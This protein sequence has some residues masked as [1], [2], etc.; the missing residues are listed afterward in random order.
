MTVQLGT[1]LPAFSLATTGQKTLTHADFIGRYSVL[2]F[3]PKDATPGCTTEGQD[4]NRLL[5]EFAKQNTSIYGVSLDS[6]ESH[7]RFKSQQGFTFELIS[8]P[9]AELSSALGVYQ[10]KKNFGKEYMGIVRSTFVIDPTG[11]ICAL[12]S[13]VKVDGHAA[14]VLQTIQQL[15]P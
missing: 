15:Q 13:P 10:L 1:P 9:Q 2:Y 3:Y 11:T 5:Q 8:D 12:W 14:E 7:E 6:I 4:F